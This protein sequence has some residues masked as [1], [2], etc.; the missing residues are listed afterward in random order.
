MARRIL[1]GLSLGAA[2]CGHCRD[3]CESSLPPH[4]CG[5]RTR[6]TTAAL[7]ESESGLAAWVS[8]LNF[9]YGKVVRWQRAKCASVSP[10]PT[11]GPLNSCCGAQRTVSGPSSTAEAC[12]RAAGSRRT[13]ARTAARG[14]ALALKACRR[15]A[16]RCPSVR[17]RRGV[18]MDLRSNVQAGMSQVKTERHWSH[19]TQNLPALRLLCGESTSHQSVRNLS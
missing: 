3:V 19:F 7:L 16:A 4:V 8:S 6:A 18:Q 10:T 9:S 11:D 14:S 17:A 12:C 1:L 5:V 15:P 2:C 13:R